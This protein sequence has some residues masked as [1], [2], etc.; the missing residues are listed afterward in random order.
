MYH[1]HTQFCA[2]HNNYLKNYLN[3]GSSTML[4]RER[5]LVALHR[6]KYVFPISIIIRRLQTGGQVRSSTFL[7][8]YH[9]CGR[10]LT[11]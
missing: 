2:S 10:A 3:T 6:Q 1:T 5:E 7:W 4:G 8:H 11:L 9:L